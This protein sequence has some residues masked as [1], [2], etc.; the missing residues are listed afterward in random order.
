M[1]KTSVTDATVKMVALLEPLDADIRRR[2]IH[3]ALTLLG[4]EHPTKSESADTENDAPGSTGK[5]PRRAEAWMRQSGLTKNEINQVFHIDGEQVEVVASR[6]VGKTNKERTLNAYLLAGIGRLLGSGEA[7]FDD[8]AARG[9]CSDLGCYDHTNH[10]T[11]LK[12]KGNTLAG[13]KDSGWK[14]TSPG[15]AQAATLVREMAKTA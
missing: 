12:D 8:K 10:A 9:L 1:N 6:I 7:S 14:L 15:L 4:D 11:Y 13:S 5:F 3:A 2:V